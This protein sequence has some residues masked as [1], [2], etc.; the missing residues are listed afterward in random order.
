MSISGSGSGQGETQVP[1]TPKAAA[2]GT[3][4]SMLSLPLEPKWQ[5]PETPNGDRPWVRYLLFPVTGPLGLGGGGGEQDTLQTLSQ[6]RTLKS[7]L[8]RWLPQG[9]LDI[10]AFSIYYYDSPPISQTTG[11]G[12]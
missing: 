2:L 5:I 11:G 1:Q 3:E 12:S 8:A 7:K 6:V 10:H 4:H 9:H